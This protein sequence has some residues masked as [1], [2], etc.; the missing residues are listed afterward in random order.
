MVRVVL[1]FNL[2]SVYISFRIYFLNCSRSLYIRRRDLV[3]IQSYDLVYM[4][5]TSWSIVFI[6][7]FAVLL[8][9]RHLFGSPH[10]DEALGPDSCPATEFYSE[11]CNGDNGYSS[12]QSTDESAE[13]A[14]RGSSDLADNS[15]AGSLFGFIHRGLSGVRRGL[16]TAVGKAYKTAK[17]TGDK[18]YSKI[19]NAT[20][21]FI[22][23]VRQV[24]REEFVYY[25]WVETALSTVADTAMAPGKFLVGID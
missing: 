11:S 20:L 14:S 1:V 3:C 23:G 16:S 25:Y 6:Y 7:S 21:E 12:T 4:A 24:L 10:E 22:E 15:D 19:K 17:D 2:F 9:S 13:M 18:M 8:F 5:M